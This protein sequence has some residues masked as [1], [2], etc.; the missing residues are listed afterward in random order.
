MRNCISALCLILLSGCPPPE[1][2]Y[3]IN[4]F[5]PIDPA[6]VGHWEGDYRTVGGESFPVIIDFNDIGFRFEGWTADEV[7]VSHGE[8]GA[9]VH[10]EGWNLLDTYFLCVDG[11]PDA[12]PLRAIWSYEIDGDVLDF[13]RD[14]DRSVEE[15]SEFQSAPFY[16]LNRVD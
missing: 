8:W 11:Y 10:Q 14:I 4:E 2:S 6:L 13:K 1:C 12:A 15:G 5:G 9:Y 16:T 3:E 7:I